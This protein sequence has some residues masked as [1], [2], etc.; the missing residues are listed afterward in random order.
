MIVDNAVDVDSRVQKSARA[1]ADAG[2]DVVVV[3]RA[4]GLDRV[5][6]RLGAIPVI[7]VPAPRWMTRQAIDDPGFVPTRP[8]AYRSE[9]Q[10]VDAGRRLQAA[11]ADTAAAVALLR[12]RIDVE[13]TA[14]GSRPV[15]AWKVRRLW[16]QVAREQRRQARRE[17][18]HERR[19]AAWRA[20]ADDVR[21]NTGWPGLARRW[22]LRTSPS[23]GWRD[24]D[25]ELA[26]VELGFG[27]EV[28]RL[29]PDLIHAH[30]FRM[31]G[32]AVRSAARARL[33]DRR[34]RVLYDVHE[35]LPGVPHRDDVWRRANE[36]MEAEFLPRAD[37]VVTVSDELAHMLQERYR[38]AV[39][40]TVVLNAPEP[41]DADVERRAPSLRERCGVG[42]GAPLLV[43]SGAVA[44]ARGLATAVAAL[45][46]LPDVHLA[47]VV[48]RRTN[49][50]VL[51]LVAQAA[52]LGVS[53]R[54]HI[55][56]YVA[57]DVVVPFLAGA[58]VG[59]IPLHHAPNHEISLITKYL[60]Y[61]A[62][63]L[64][65]VVSD[66][67][68][69]AAFTREHGNGEVFPAED[70]EGFATAA[71]AVLAEPPATARPTPQGCATS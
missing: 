20:N 42:P 25:L 7:L 4:E 44:P 37:A 18:A 19:L 56:R 50:Y 9:R 38:L 60:E 61:V 35:W 52:D 71:R 22:R 10:S 27:S 54:L 6:K 21:S 17:T 40:P 69:M 59:L 70:V 12:D 53:D 67:R 33:R 49:P 15:R 11:K 16:Q 41:T 1:A 13:K 24:V 3:G 46:Q 66:V 63:D 31:I 39:T 62:A 58:D 43:Y 14:G 48:G 5:E 36:A 55:T 51:E 28:D 2:Y 23:K 34:V 45:P 64:P 57:P 68:T 29:E 8:R 47:L 32:V 30:D 65:M 26:D